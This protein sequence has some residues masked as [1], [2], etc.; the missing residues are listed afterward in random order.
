MGSFFSAVIAGLLSF[1]SPCILPLLPVYVGILTNEVDGQGKGIV[2]RCVNI[3]GFVLGICCIFV[4]LGAGAGA[5][6]SVLDNAYLGI[7]LGVVVIVFGL[8]LAGIAK[9]PLLEGEIR[10]DLSKIHTNGFVGTFVLGVAFSFGWTPCV[11]PILGSILALAADAQSAT[12]GA[13]LLLA[14]SLGLCVPFVVIALAA[15]IIMGRLAGIRRYLPTVQKFG[16]ILIAVMGAWLIFSQINALTVKQAATGA[17]TEQTDVSASSAGFEQDVS[18]NDARGTSS[19]DADLDGISGAWKNVVLTDLDGNKHRMS[20]YWGKPLYFEFWGSWCDSCV[21]DLGQI[22]QIAEEHNQKGDVEVVSVVTPGFFGERDTAD[23]EAWARD[24]DVTV[25]VFMDTNCS[26]ATYLN[27]SAFPT[28]VFVGSDG[29]IQ[30]I[31]LGAI[32]RDELEEM[33]TSLN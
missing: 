22:T 11:G 5:I 24:N 8:H 9:I 10:A 30:K 19:G 31:R 33:L 4:S 2:G 12:A 21:A 16:G 20:D 1:F 27:V 28:S 7:A 17:Q 3:T 23:F 14:Y 15:N 18:V 13:V 26:L 25:P 29:Q 32:E 6:G